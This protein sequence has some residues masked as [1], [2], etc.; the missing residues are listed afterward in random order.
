MS[1]IISIGKS[2]TMYG[3]KVKKLNMG[4]HLMLMSKLKDFEKDLMEKVFNNEFDKFLDGVTELSNKSIIGLVGNAL[5]YCP[6]MIIN[7]MAEVLEVEREKLLNNE[8]IG[9]YEMLEIIETFI[10]INRLVE[11]F[12]KGKKLIMKYIMNIGC[13]S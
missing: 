8:E 11:T 13:K 6:E 1:E 7:F 9:L 10:E 3:I 12:D 5:L 2:K 4:K